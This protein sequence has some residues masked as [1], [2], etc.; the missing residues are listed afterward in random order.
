VLPLLRRTFAGF[1]AAERANLASAL[2]HLAGGAPSLAAAEPADP[3]RAAGVLQTVAAI[4]AGP[5]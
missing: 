3:R 1:S 2:Q 4:L 5:S